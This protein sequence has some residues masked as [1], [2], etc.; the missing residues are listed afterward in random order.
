MCGPQTRVLCMGLRLYWLTVKK[1]KRIFV[2]EVYWYNNTIHKSFD[3]IVQLLQK[4]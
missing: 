1:Q 3:T 2:H 4:V